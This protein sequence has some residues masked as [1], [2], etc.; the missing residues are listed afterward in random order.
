MKKIFLLFI[1]LLLAQFSYSQQILEY[2]SFKKWQKNSIST[3]VS[4][5]GLC[6]TATVAYERLFKPQLV[7]PRIEGKNKSYTKQWLFRLES[8]YYG[9]IDYES[10]LLIVPQVG[11]LHSL[12][13]EKNSI[14]AGAGFALLSFLP[15][16][17]SPKYPN[18]LG[19]SNLLPAVY[20]GYR[21][22]K[23]DK[24]RFFRVGASYPQGGYFSF[25]LYTKSR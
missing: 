4:V 15:N 1:T 13:K 16:Y 22:Q 7:Q 21:R 10:S 9:S 6:G 18:L 5:C 25:G 23:P 11:Y 17:G 14:E 24:R 20:L 3:G 12:A 2:P 8:G 19:G